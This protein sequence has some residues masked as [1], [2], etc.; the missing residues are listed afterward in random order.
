MAWAFESIGTQENSSTS[1]EIVITAPSGIQVD[2]LLVANIH[3][4]HNGNATLLGWTLV[5][6]TAS[7]NNSSG[8]MLYKIAVSADTSAVDYTFAI[9]IT[10]GFIGSVARYSG[11]DAVDSLD[12]FATADST[13]KETEIDT[14]SVTTTND[15]ALV[16]RH[17]SQDGAATATI[18]FSAAQDPPTER[19]D[20]DSDI[21]SG[22][23]VG[24]A[25][26]DEIKVSA[27]ATGIEIIT[28]SL[29]EQWCAITA[30]F[31]VSADTTPDLSWGPEFPAQVDEEI[32][33]D[34]YGQV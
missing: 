19:S 5:A 18:T 30:A 14:P 27:G 31:N 29:S 34:S 13:T 1:T 23:E 10:D 2:D 21:G 32:T 9:D 24:G 8:D 17:A 12:V 33:I 7:G 20:M 6:H 4:N 26:Y 15:N 25:S 3:M 28:C 22:A 16:I 11:I